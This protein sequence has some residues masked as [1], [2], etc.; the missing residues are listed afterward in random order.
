MVKVLSGTLSRRCLLWFM[1]WASCSTRAARTVSYEQFMH[2][3]CVFL[4][5]LLLL[6]LLLQG[7]T[8]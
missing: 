5:L 6:L 4:L 2:H 3:S 1:N 8:M 7:R